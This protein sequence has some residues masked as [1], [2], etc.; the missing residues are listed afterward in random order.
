MVQ[1]RRS[2]SRPP[3]VEVGLYGVSSRGAAL[4]FLWISVALAVV[5]LI[6]GFFFLPLFLGALF[7]VAALWY[8]LA[9]KWVD[10]NDRWA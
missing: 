10:Q 7:G 5:C 6:A 4:A 3:W 2:N 1:E 9:I 8:W